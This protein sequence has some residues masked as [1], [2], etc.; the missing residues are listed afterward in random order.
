MGNNNITI[1]SGADVTIQRTHDA[2]AGSQCG[3]IVK[4]GG[5]LTMINEMLVSG[6][7]AVLVVEGQVV[8]NKLTMGRGTVLAVHSGGSLHA[9]HVET[10]EEVSILMYSGGLV[11]SVASQLNPVKLISFTIGPASQLLFEYAAVDIE[12]DRLELRWN[13]LLTSMAE[14]KNIT[15]RCSQAKVH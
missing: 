2:S 8:T 10:N 11:G 15:I 6:Y 1:A 14:E 12:V 13:S 9:D 7:A 5:T 3:F 4:A